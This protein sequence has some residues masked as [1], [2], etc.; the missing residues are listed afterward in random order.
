M[1]CFGYMKR[2]PKR[3][4]ENR[5]ETSGKWMVLFRTNLAFISFSSNMSS[6]SILIEV[7]ESH[8]NVRWSQVIRRNTKVI[9]KYPFCQ[10]HTHVFISYLYIHD[11]FC[12]SIDLLSLLFFYSSTMTMRC[13]II[14]YVTYRFEKG[15]HREKALSEFSLENK[16]TNKSRQEYSNKQ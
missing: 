6:T 16:H 5:E 14:L 8:F 4:C 2:M 1:V 11:H 7:C 15:S 13:F 10:W 9:I 12:L 3:K